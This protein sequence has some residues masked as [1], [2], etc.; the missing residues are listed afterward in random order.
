M[1]LHSGQG[2]MMPLPGGVTV[3][4]MS[5]SLDT[6][7]LPECTTEVSGF[8][9]SLGSPLQYCLCGWDGRLGRLD[10]GVAA[11]VRQYVPGFA[12]VHFVGFL[13]GDAHSTALIDL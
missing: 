7:Y 2:M 4:A 6:G 9:L 11:A 5:A 1:S 3:V 13:G 8:S 10:D 12:K